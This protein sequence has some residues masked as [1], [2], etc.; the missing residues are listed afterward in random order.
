MKSILVNK[1]ELF[2]FHFYD[3]YLEIER[4]GRLTLNIL[5][6]DVVRCELKKGE[7]QITGTLLVGFFVL[8]LQLIPGIPKK[9]FKEHDQLLIQLKNKKTLSY[10]ISRNI[11]RI[12]INKVVNSIKMN[13]FK[14]K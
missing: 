4:K 12:K 2:V 1:E 10:Q 6:E 3:N 9:I 11:D 14:F 5:Y 8:V 13:T 7:T